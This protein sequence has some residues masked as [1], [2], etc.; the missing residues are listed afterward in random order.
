MKK[1]DISESR[2]TVLVVIAIPS[3]EMGC[4]SKIKESRYSHARPAVFLSASMA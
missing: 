1:D 3:R 4:W 2:H